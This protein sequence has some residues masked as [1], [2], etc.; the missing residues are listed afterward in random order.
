MGW[1]GEGGT[2]KTWTQSFEGK[3]KIGVGGFENEICILQLGI[4]EGILP[5][6]KLALRHDLGREKD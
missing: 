1:R 6:E 5:W 3:F 2:E 4:C